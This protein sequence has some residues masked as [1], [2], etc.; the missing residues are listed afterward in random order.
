MKM[1]RT[2]Q[3]VVKNLEKMGRCY[4]PDCDQYDP[5]SQY[6][7]DEEYE[8]EVLDES[9]SQEIGNMYR[10]LSRY[11]GVD[12]NE[13][14]YGPNGFMETKYPDGFSISAEIIYL[15]DKWDEFEQW[16]KEKHGIDF[17]AIREKNRKDSDDY[18]PQLTTD[19]MAAGQWYE[20]LEDEEGLEE[21]AGG[22]ALDMTVEDIAEKH[23]VDVVILKN[24]SRSA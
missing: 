6:F 2:V 22:N 12:L 13:L 17:E 18:E 16:M 7:D 8:D 9:Q 20:A 15:K 23:G 3:N 1:K 4:N 19:R 14:V 21:A 5:L 10:R 24:K 11:Y